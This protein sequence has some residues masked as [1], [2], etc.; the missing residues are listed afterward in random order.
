MIGNKLSKS[1]E[2]GAG[3]LKVAAVQ[4][5]K[6]VVTDHFLNGLRPLG[7]MHQ[8]LAHQC[9]AYVGEMLMICQSRYLVATQAGHVFDVI[10]GDHAS[11]SLH[12]ELAVF[13]VYRDTARFRLIRIN[14]DKFQKPYPRFRNPGCMEDRKC[15]D[16]Q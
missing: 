4:R 7:L 10:Q 12:F 3:M 5:D 8:V 9:R 1:A 6:Y 16:W 14:A 13:P 11:H 2:Q 15:S